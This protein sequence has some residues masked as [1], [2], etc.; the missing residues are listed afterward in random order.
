MSTSRTI[1]ACAL[2][3]LLALPLGA[4]GVGGV[5][6]GNGLVFAKI[7]STGSFDPIGIEVTLRR[8]GSTI[9]GETI[10]LAL[11]NNPGMLLVHGSR[12]YVERVDPNL[13]SILD[14]L[15]GAFSNTG[16]ISGLHY[17]PA[18]NVIFVQDTSDNLYSGD[19]LTGALTLVTTNSCEYAKGLA[20]DGLGRHITGEADENADPTIYQ[21]DPDDGT[22][23]ALGELDYAHGIDS[24]NGFATDPVSGTIYAIIDSE[25]DAGVAEDD[26]RNL[27]SINT[28]ALTSSIVGSVSEDATPGGDGC[29][30]IAMGVNGQLYMISGENDVYETLYTVNKATGAVAPILQLG[31]DDDGESLTSQPAQLRGTLT[32]VTNANGVA[33]FPGVMLDCVAGGYTLSATATGGEVAVSNPFDIVAP[34]MSATVSFA[35]A[36]STF[37]EGVAVQTIDITV[38]EAQTHPIF[39]QIHISGGSARNSGRR[40]FPTN[41]YDFPQAPGQ[42][43]SS[44][45]FVTIPAGTTTFALQ[46][47]AVADGS[48][49]GSQD[50]ELT[51]GNEEGTG[52]GI[53]LAVAGAQTT[54]TITIN[55]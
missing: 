35:S 10:T 32:A 19:S 42:G 54:H 9:A 36:T 45:F 17:D 25:E 26:E 38:S 47:V 40:D 16:E 8:G 21:V 48:P 12:Q 31:F 3:A 29:A 22:C 49:E 18:R 53:G 51:L 37:S 6:P 4:C 2:L 5:K 13:P 1:Y 23:I 15:P 7:A 44:E 11:A 55:D 50:L 14:P 39:L 34:D 27:V 33:T 28:V 46:F 52:G 20:L 41:D 24:F 43:G 30:S